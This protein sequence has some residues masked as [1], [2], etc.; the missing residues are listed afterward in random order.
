VIDLANRIR[1]SDRVRITERVDALATRLAD[2]DWAR[3]SR[4]SRRRWAVVLEVEAVAVFAIGGFVLVRVTGA[5]AIWGIGAALYLWLAI[6]L[7]LLVDRPSNAFRWAIY[8]L[9]LFMLIG[10]GAGL[11]AAM[12]SG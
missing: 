5:T 9:P 4:E 7:A 11:V 6:F 12:T 10:I 2:V 3:R 1:Q 8:S